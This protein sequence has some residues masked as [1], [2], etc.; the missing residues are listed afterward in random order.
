VHTGAFRIEKYLSL[1]AWL[2]ASGGVLYRQRNIRRGGI[3]LSAI[4]FIACDAAEAAGCA[5]VSV[6]KST[7]ENS[8]APNGNKQRREK[9]KTESGERTGGR[10]DKS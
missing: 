9:M 1:R 10:T 3:L 4:F 7:Q 2:G 8:S 6:A 5:L